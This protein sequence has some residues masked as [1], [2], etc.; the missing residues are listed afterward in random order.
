MNILN[1]DDI[2]ITGF[3]SIRER[4]LLQDRRYFRHQIP[5]ECRDGF[6]ACVYLANAWFSP[7]G[8]TGLHHHRG[9]DI[10]SLVPRG[11]LLHQGSIGDGE[12]VLAGQ[13]QLQ[14]D[15]GQGFRHNEINPGAG[16]QPLIQLW[17]DPQPQAAQTHYRIL[18]PAAEGLSCVY[19]GELFPSALRVDVLNWT[20]GGELSVA[21]P[22]LLYVYAGQGWLQEGPHSARLQQGLLADAAGFH[23]RS[24]GLLRLLLIREVSHSG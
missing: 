6:G 24:D 16:V 7:G 18:Q 23:L 12:Q 3:A 1:E 2:A 13:V 19:G 14:R 20:T 17:I 22:A 15:G 11:S 9:V 10:L 4:V 8:S 21:G 5:D